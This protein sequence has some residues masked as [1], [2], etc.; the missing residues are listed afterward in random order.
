[1]DAVRISPAYVS[2]MEINV[3]GPVEVIDAGN[4]VDLGGRKQKTVLAM[5]VANAGKPVS[6]DNLINAVYG[7]EAPDGARRSV[8][9]YVSN[10]RSTMGD[11]ITAAGSGYEFRSLDSTVDAEEFITHMET[12]RALISEDPGAASSELQI[13]LALWRGHPF[14]DAEARSELDAEIT[15]FNELR[16]VAIESRVDADL[17]A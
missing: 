4:R 16:L 8:Q 13:A 5:L 11:M 1:M 2:T 7:D 9:T 12:G 10:L 17:A 15:R 3:L 14:Q 6:T